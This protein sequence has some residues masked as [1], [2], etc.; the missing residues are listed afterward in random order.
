MVS[1]TRDHSGHEAVHSSHKFSMMTRLPV[2]DCKA[3]AC[4]SVANVAS[5]FCRNAGIAQMFFSGTILHLTCGR[6]DASCRRWPQVCM[7]ALNVLCSSDGLSAV[8][9][10]ARPCVRPC[11]RVCVLACVRTCVLACVR[12]CVCACACARVHRCVDGWMGG[13]AG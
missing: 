12:A 3:F 5:S 11:G 13:W 7:S 2:F 1:T 8:C 4:S 9:V 10:R 6:L